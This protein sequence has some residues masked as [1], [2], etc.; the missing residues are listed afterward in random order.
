MRGSSFVTAAIAAVLGCGAGCAREES[1]TTGAA[2]RPV[3]GGFPSELEAACGMIATLPPDPENPDGVRDPLHCSCVLVGPRV[4]L[5]AASCVDEN[6]E[7]GTLDQIDLRFG[8]GYESGQRN[9][10]EAIELYRYFEPDSG[11]DDDLALLLLAAPA[12]GP[13]D[14]P[15]TPVEINAE[16]LGEELVQM[17]VQLVGY[18]RDAEARQFGS[19]YVIDAPIVSVNENHLLAGTG[20]ATS[21]YGDAGGPVLFDFG[22]GPVLIAV[23][24]RNG[25]GVGP[26]CI[27]QTIRARVDRYT[28]TFLFPY[29]DRTDGP[30]ALGGGCIEEGCRSPDPD[31]EPCLWNDMCEEDCP[32]RDLDCEIGAFPGEACEASGQCERGG[33]C[34]AAADDESFTYCSQPCDAAAAEPGCP[35]NMTCTE[36]EGGESVCT[37]GVPSPGSQGAPCSTGLDCRSDICEEG[38]CVNTCDSD[39]DCP[40]PPAGE[41]P[42]RCSD[43]QEEPGER[44]CLGEIISGGGGFCAPSSVSAAAGGGGRARLAGI[45]LLALAALALV[46][47]ARRRG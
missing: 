26:D 10:I 44:V 3:T 45:A 43:S 19:R 23:N 25:D 14:A 6:A 12:V 46:W 31:C 8:S 35:P 30:C 16:P 5:T 11:S 40:D 34:I 32:T 18:G 29:L 47:M 7:A 20:T 36:A 28:T 17:T 13:G 37:Y 41:E 21:C 24:G 42:Y 33:T 4:V 38:I 2:A 9:D 1:A 15:I 39:E 22:D 27:T